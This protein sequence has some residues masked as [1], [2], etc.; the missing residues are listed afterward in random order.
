MSFWAFIRIRMVAAD[1]IAFAAVLAASI[2][3]IL[4]V[5]FAAFAAAI[6][7]Y[8]LTPFPPPLRDIGPPYSVAISPVI[9]R[10]GDA[11]GVLGTCDRM[12]KASRRERYMWRPPRSRTIRCVESDL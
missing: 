11:T 8:I 1:T 12:H 2:A 5:I 3:V 9:R 4:A 10:F 7:G 6:L